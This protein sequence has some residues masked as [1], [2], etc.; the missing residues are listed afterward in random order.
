MT[1][2]GSVEVAASPD[3]IWEA[4]ADPAQM[5]RWSPENTGSPVGAGQPLGVGAVFHGTNKRGP[6]RW[7]TECKVTDSERGSRFAFNVYAIGVKKPWL[8]YK[9]ARWDFVLEP[10]G[11]G[12]K[13]TEIWTDGRDRWPD[14]SARVFDKFATGTTFHQFQQRNIARTLKNLKADFER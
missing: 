5:P 10:A 3:E 9:I 12:A 4:L 8:R 2:Q 6:A 13:V 7:T 11:S 14:W 1:V